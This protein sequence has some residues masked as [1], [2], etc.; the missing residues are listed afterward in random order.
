[1]N[2]CNCDCV[3]AASVIKQGDAL[4]IGVELS[5]TT[6]CGDDAVVSQV[7]EA[8]LVG[9]EAIIDKVEFML[10]GIFRWVY[11]DSASFDDTDDKFLLPMTQEQSFQLIPDE[12]VDLDVRVKFKP[13]YTRGPIVVGLGGRRPKLRVAASESMEV[14]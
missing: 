11:P 9:A 2:E 6:G 14:L 7:T 1:M 5:L 13:E 3:C 8:D 12:D 4:N 10:G